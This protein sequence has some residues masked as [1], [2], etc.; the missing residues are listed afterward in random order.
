MS[1]PFAEEV[2]VKPEE[3]HVPR[4]RWSWKKFWAY[5]GPG[6]LMSI[7]YL[8]PGNI[9]ADLQSG[10][11]G[12]FS[13]GCVNVMRPAITMSALSLNGLCGHLCPKLQM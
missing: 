7:A 6:W 3:V 11:A 2:R 5:A 8:D 1:Q 9:E 10:I 4:N 12:G 13:L